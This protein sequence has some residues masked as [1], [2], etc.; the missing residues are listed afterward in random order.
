MPD[1]FQTIRVF[2]VAHDAHL[3]ASK[4]E[5]Q[6]LRGIKGV[7]LIKIAKAILR[8][9]NPPCGRRG[10]DVYCGR[11]YGFDKPVLYLRGWRNQA[12][13]QALRRGAGN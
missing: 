13:G 5:S 4:L 8:A 3:V 12:S 6:R 1:S 9:S 11:T 7:M 10:K 2:N